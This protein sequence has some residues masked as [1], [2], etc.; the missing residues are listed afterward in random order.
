MRVLF[1]V[2]DWPGHYYP[3][4]PLGWALQAAG[5]EVRVV[6]ASSQTG[7]LRRTGL[8]PVPLVE[9]GLEM[10]VQGRLRNFWD[11]QQGRWPHP[12]PPPHPLTG[13]PLARLDDFDFAAFRAADRPRIARA[14]SDNFDA[15]VGFARAWRPDLV[16]HDRMSI[17]GLLAARVL[18]V[19]AVLHLW[20]PHGTAE[21]EPELRVIPGDPT[22]SFPRH[23]V[24]PMGPELIEYVIDP[25]PPSLEPPTDARRLRMRHIA[26]NGPGPDPGIGP[27]P[28][29]RPRVCVV[30]GHSVTRMYGPCS[31]LLPELAASFTDLGA[32]IM[33]LAGP[34]DLA[35]LGEPPPGTRVMENVPLRT[36]L[37]GSAAVVHYGG[38]GCTMTAVAAGVPQLGIPFSAEQ[39]LNAGRVAKAG[40]GL[41]VP[42]SSPD[43]SARGRAALR[44]LL[45]EPSF[46]QTAARL[47]EELLAT[48]APADLV[49]VLEELAAAA[50]V[51]AP[52]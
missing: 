1:T 16:V 29:G 18:G 10:A 43:R 51:P 22:G 52:R 4:V 25:C 5:H 9:P 21:P 15:V 7:T 31:R 36:V 40:A 50:R 11:A 19:P 35:A 17:E 37:P 27:P 12:E 33:L 2:S 48:P 20:G 34:A 30:W 41:V 44:R 42:A 28:A 38:S 24:P 8:T 13:E 45:A 32:E 6:C 39:A 47:G 46:R 23:G 14:T 3:L 49:P 26:Y